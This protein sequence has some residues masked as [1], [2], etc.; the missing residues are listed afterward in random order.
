M[1]R[2]FISYRRQ[3]ADGHAGWIAD[4]LRQR[5]HDVRTDVGILPGEDFVDAIRR[6]IG[7]CDAL[8]VVI[9]P[10]WLD[11][12]DSQGRRRL[13][14]EEDWVRFEIQEGL[15]ATAVKVIPVLIRKAQMPGSAD[16]PVEI[17]R[18]ARRNA[19]E[20]TPKHWE[21]DMDQL[22]AAITRQP[23][24]VA[25]I[26]AVCLGGALLLAIPG[27]AAYDAVRGELKV[28]RTDDLWI[29]RQA[30]VWFCLWSLVVAGACGAAA[31]ALR[32]S[33]PDA[34][35]SALKGLLVGA[36]AGAV[37]GAI[38][39]ALRIDPGVDPVDYFPAYAVLG[40]IVGA[41]VAPTA[42]RAA[43]ALGGAAGGV[44]AGLIVFAIEQAEPTGTFNDPRSAQLIAVALIIGGAVAAGMVAQVDAPQR[45]SLVRAE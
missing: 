4:A 36:L 22:S 34:L 15:G 1:A 6:S 32:R 9:G 21:Y 2:V 8:L 43:S 27:L 25:L 5:G 45:R 26:A 20:L 24:P 16:L 13:D 35:R 40:L 39:A 31:L 41:M 30:F 18:F 37:G 14:A 17:A 7:W 11:L 12:R 3:E 28:N 33:A 38:T 29:P 44:L 42:E 19:Q 10:Q 23:L